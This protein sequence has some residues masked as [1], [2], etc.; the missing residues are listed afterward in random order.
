MALTH[1]RIRRAKELLE[2]GDREIAKYRNDA[3]QLIKIMNYYYLSPV[4][5]L[6]GGPRLKSQLQEKYAIAN[7]FKYCNLLNFLTPLFCD[8]IL[9]AVTYIVA[10]VLMSAV[11]LPNWRK[12]SYNNGYNTLFGD[13]G[14]DLRAYMYG[15][16][17]KYS[18]ICQF[19]TQ[20][21]Y[22]QP[23]NSTYLCNL[24]MDSG[25]DLVPPVNCSTVLNDAINVVMDAIEMEANV[26]IDPNSYINSTYTTYV[27]NPLVE[28]F[29][30][31]IICNRTALAIRES[32]YVFA[33]WVQCFFIIIILSVPLNLVILFLIDLVHSRINEVDIETQ[34][35]LGGNIN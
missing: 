14:N 26:Y 24:N 4:F 5:L 16:S 17:R 9:I 15:C 35:L 34:I 1:Q 25:C 30:Q 28:N 8:E 23:A 6:M 12:N 18:D 32:E 33:E 10:I 2:I 31:P 21:V 7:R 22:C 11:W 29:W 19:C 3:A 27:L 13:D 20:T